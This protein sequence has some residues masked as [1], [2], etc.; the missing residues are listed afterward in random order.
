[1][2]GE[3]RKKMGEG[4]GGGGGGGGG[5]QQTGSVLRLS[6]VAAATQEGVKKG[7][8]ITN[9]VLGDQSFKKTKIKNCFLSLCPFFFV[10]NMIM[11]MMIIRNMMI[12]L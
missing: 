11:N 12:I 7:V 4:G 8:R 9:T 2:E 1:M 10:L 3:Q 5:S 6:A